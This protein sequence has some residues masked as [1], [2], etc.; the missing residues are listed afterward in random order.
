MKAINEVENLK[1][2][3]RENKVIVHD[4]IHASAI[5][6]RADNTFGFSFIT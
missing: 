1:F 5:I 2:R 6:L 4:V 3:I